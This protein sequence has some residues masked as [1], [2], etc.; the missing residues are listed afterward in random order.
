M[1]LHYN[2]VA[3]WLFPSSCNYI[4]G[5][6]DFGVRMATVKRSAQGYEISPLYI[7]EDQPSQRQELVYVWE[8]YCELPAL[9]WVA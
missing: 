3:A 6:V 8:F 7:T 4:R 2:H 9:L 1:R 5:N